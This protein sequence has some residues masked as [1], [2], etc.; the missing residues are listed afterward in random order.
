MEDTLSIA[1]HCRCRGIY[2]IF[3][4]EH[5]ERLHTKHRDGASADASKG[6]VLRRLVSTLA[7]VYG[8]GG[9]N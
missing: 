1:R 4:F 5:V 2:L 8:D 7:N 9:R 3:H 6:M